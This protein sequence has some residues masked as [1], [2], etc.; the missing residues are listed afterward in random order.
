[1]QK[2]DGFVVNSGFTAMHLVNNGLLQKKVF[3]PP[4]I[5]FELPKKKVKEIPPIKVLLVA[6]LAE[7]KGIL[8]FLQLVEDL[9][10]IHISEPTRPY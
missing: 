10:L 1:M 9:S 5:D 3:I 4:A 2:F 8:P 6:N 7:R